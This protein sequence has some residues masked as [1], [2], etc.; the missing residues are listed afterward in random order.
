VHRPGYRL[1]VAS[2]AAQRCA[3]GAGLCPSAGR[4]NAS[5]DEVLENWLTGEPWF[6][7]EIMRLTT[8]IQEATNG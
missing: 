6:P 5:F 4:K 1:L 7:R 8:K 3:G 2:D